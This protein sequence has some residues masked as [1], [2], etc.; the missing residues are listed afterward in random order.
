MEIR[1]GYAFIK[2]I[3]VFYCGHGHI[4]KINHC[5]MYRNHN[6]IQ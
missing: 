5:V 3:G 4:D 6:G 2:A 1:V